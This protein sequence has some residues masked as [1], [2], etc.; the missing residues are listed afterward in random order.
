MEVD[1]FVEDEIEAAEF[2]RISAQAAK[3]VIIH[4][5]REAER[6]KVAD[7]YMDRVG[8]LVTGVIKRIEKGSVYMDLGGNADAYIRVNI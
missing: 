8:E 4:K 1:D 7:A 5:V 3:Q 2:G 6:K